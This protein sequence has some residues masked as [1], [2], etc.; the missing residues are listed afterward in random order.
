ML[1]E[2]E[3]LYGGTELERWAENELSQLQNVALSVSELTFRDGEGDLDIAERIDVPAKLVLVYKNQRP[4]GLYLQTIQT[5]KLLRIF[6]EGPIDFSDLEDGF[7]RL[8]V[9]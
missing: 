9:L 4:I 8:S 5:K 2:R 3:S 1:I 7:Y 6:E